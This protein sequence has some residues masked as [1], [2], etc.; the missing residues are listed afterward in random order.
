MEKS[1]PTGGQ[2]AISVILGAFITGFMWRCRG[3]SG[4]GSS[5]GL[6]SVALVL[7]LFIYQL[8]GKRTGMKYEKI[9]IGALMMMLGVTGYATVID[10]L[11]GTVWSD[12]PYPVHGGVPMRA[13]V[14]TESAAI[15]IIAM[16]F[17]LVPLFAFFIGSLFSDKEYK[18]RHYVI[19]V[20]LFFAVSTIV[21]ATVAHPILQ[22]INPDQVEWAAKG[23]A[24]FGIDLS[25][26][27]AYMTHFLN[28]DFSQDIAFNENYYMSIEHI[29][30]VFGVIA[31]A[32]YALIGRRDKT[33]F[34]ST[35][36]IDG[37]VAL[38]TTALSPL[39][40]LEAVKAEIDP[41][42]NVP[43]FIANGN[44]WGLWEYS[45]G[46]CVGFITMLF[47]ALLPKKKTENTVED[48]MPMFENKTGNLIFN[49]IIT[50]FAFGVV[51]GRVIGI[52][53]AKLLK[54]TGVMEDVGPMG[55][56]ICAVLAVV[57][58]FFMF[59]RLYG[60]LFGGFK[61][62][63][64]VG[65]AEFSKKA[66][67]GYFYMCA[68]AYFFLNHAEIFF[69]PYDRMATASGF[70]QV[71]FSEDLVITV[72]IATLAIISLIYL[73]LRKKLK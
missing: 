68:A 54:N 38:G 28:R 35:I 21:K 10:Q 63:I 9:P 48:K 70:A 39:I 43:E 17:T 45:T 69:L 5:W 26:K 40:S 53:F 34:A 6:F 13:P 55:E 14:S 58:A 30:D 1:Y 19:A 60:F 16:G 22:A 73:P 51:P 62:I 31:V 33:A 8:Y 61:N 11:S 50:V 12:L 24:D 27:D 66:F 36:V 42:V 57:F 65:P 47:I 37:F 15:I 23:L 44:G 7:M 25:P 56:I 64:G 29:S 41:S 46:F 59:K 18:I 72:M 49:F 52:R 3:E 67:V 4:W 32:L 71:M 20:V 2:K